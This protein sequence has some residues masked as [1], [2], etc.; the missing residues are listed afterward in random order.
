MLLM[1]SFV[2]QLSF[3]EG[4]SVQEI[5]FQNANA[6]HDGVPFTGWLWDEE[7]RCRTQYVAGLRNGWRFYYFP[8]GK[9]R[10]A[11][12]Y[13]KD[14]KTGTHLGWWPNGQLRFSKS[15]VAGLYHGKTQAWYSDGG[16]ALVQNYVNGKEQGPQKFWQENGTLYA[17]YVVKDGRRFGLIGSKPCSTLS[18]DEDQS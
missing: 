4:L 15:Y 5:E 2:C 14:R 1:M 13:L 12:C 17:N 7:H 16:L 3:I 18:E 9:L 11:R 8:D 6:L 10:E